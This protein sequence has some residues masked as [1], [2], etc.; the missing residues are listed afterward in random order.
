M[1]SGREASE[2]LREAGV[3]SDFV[4]PGNPKIG[5]NVECLMTNV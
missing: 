2:I 3:L 4:I 1:I 5:G